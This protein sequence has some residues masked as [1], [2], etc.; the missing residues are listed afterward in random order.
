MSLARPKSPTLTMT[1]FE[2]PSGTS[3]D[4]RQFRAAISLFHIQYNSIID[5]E[6]DDSCGADDD[7]NDDVD[8]VYD[9]SNSTANA[10][11]V[12]TNLPGIR[13]N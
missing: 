6:D 10:V 1:S 13:S 7:N 4:T 11:R 3:L 5:D 9:M 12:E 8:D 2:L